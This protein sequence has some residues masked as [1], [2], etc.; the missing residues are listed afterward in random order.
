VGADDLAH[1]FGYRIVPSHPDC[2]RL[3]LHVFARAYREAWIALHADAPSGRHWFER[4]GI[5]ID[6]GAPGGNPLSGPG[7][8]NCI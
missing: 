5:A 7:I 2:D 6:F 3:Q 8:V 4:L 1:S